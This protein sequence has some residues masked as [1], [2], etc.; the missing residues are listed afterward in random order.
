MLPWCRRCI[1]W[2]SV[3]IIFGVVLVP[4]SLSKAQQ[5]MGPGPGDWP[6][7]D[8][9]GG[10]TKVSQYWLG[11]VSEPL[12][13]TLRTHLKLQ[14]NEG[15]LVREVAPK[16]PAATAKIQRNDVVLRAEGK[17]LT[18]I[19]D[20]ITAVE[21]SRGHPMTLEV[22]RQ[23][24]PTTVKVTPAKRPDGDISKLLPPTGGDPGEAMRKWLETMGGPDVPHGDYRFFYLRPGMVF[25]RS[26]G[27]VELPENMTIAITKQGKTPLHVV[28]TRGKEKWD[29]NE[30]EFDKL[31]PDIRRHVDAMLSRGPRGLTMG[32]SLPRPLGSTNPEADHEQ[33]PGM[34]SPPRTAKTPDAQLESLGRQV[35]ALR[36]AIEELKQKP[37]VPSPPVPGPQTSEKPGGK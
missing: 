10:P 34:F 9:V 11:V 33:H 37:A 21:T 29:V 23:G 28:V 32:P 14:E 26:G 35:E 3:A 20:L 4:A 8:D 27:A 18:K 22:I 24:K 5:P 12:P 6:R 19:D 16:S 7:N 17:T 30:G 13:E 1:G 31:P 25:G 36:K 15:L 2:V